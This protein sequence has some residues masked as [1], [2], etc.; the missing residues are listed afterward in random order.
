VAN[1]LDLMWQ[2]VNLLIIDPFPPGR[3]D[4]EGIHAAIWS[5]LSDDPFVLP[6][7]KPLTIASY[8]VDPIKTA[9]VETIA[10]GE[11]LPDMALFLEGEFY[12]TV[13]LE[14]TYQTTWNVL[15]GEI[16]ALL[17]PPAS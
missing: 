11:A 16:R 1:A 7:D 10:V 3:R 13:P 9:Y 4:P 2:G 12:I 6:G 17:E 8:Q 5:E 14:E 15:P